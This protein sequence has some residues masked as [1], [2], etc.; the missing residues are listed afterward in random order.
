MPGDIR[1]GCARRVDDLSDGEFPPLEFLEDAEP[2]RVPE[3]PEPL[4]YQVQRSLAQRL[5]RLPGQ[6]SAL[7]C[8]PDPTP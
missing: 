2:E 3:D 4:G 7:L 8:S 6:G 5:F 1:L